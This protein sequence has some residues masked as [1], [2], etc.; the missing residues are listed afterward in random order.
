VADLPDALPRLLVGHHYGVLPLDLFV[1]GYTHRILLF[2]LL[3]NRPTNL[4][5]DG[6]DAFF[7]HHDGAA[8]LDFLLHGLAAVD[9]FGD[10]SLLL[11]VLTTGDR[12]RFRDPFGAVNRLLDVA[13]AAATATRSDAGPTGNGLT[14]R[15]H[16][17]HQ[18]QRKNKTT[19]FLPPFHQSNS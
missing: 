18:R 16:E 1:L 14:C 17:P 10:L 4:V 13:R 8:T 5:R 11:L 12:S 9:R 3:Y 15:K 2:D 7:G 6:F 19:H